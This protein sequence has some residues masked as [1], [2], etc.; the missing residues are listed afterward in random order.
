MAKITYSNKSTLNPQPS[1]ASKNKVTS[2]DMNEIKQV[3]NENDD[4]LISQ[5][6]TIN[7]IKGTILWTNP[8]PNSVFTTQNITLDSDDYDILEIYM[9]LNSGENEIISQKVIKGY[10]TTLQ[11]NIIAN[12]KVYHRIRKF[13]RTNDTTYSVGTGY[14]QITNESTYSQADSSL[15]P[16][17]IVGYKTGLF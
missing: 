13:N 7:N 10:N 16:I 5:G 17:Y 3:V 14:Q 8:N 9:K 6:N 2:D 4:T 12:N 11:G 15:V 1:I